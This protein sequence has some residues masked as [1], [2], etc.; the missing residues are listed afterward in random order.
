MKTARDD[1]IRRLNSIYANMLNKSN[2]SVI[3]GNAEFVDSK[4]LKVGN[5]FYSSDHICISVGG[6]P[7]MPK[8]PGVEHCLSSD[9]FFKLTKQPKKV[10]VYGGG[11]IGLEIAGVFHSLGTDTTLF[12]RGSPFQQFDELIRDTLL[13]ELSRQQLTISSGIE[14][15]EIKKVKDGELYLIDQQDRRHGPFE[16]ILMAI[17]RQPVTDSLSLSAANVQIDKNGFIPVNEY[18]ETSSRGIYAIGD[19]C[20]RMPTL[21]PM[22]IAAG[23]RLADRYA[24]I[25]SPPPSELSP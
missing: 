3:H 7:M 10:A 23:R 18:Q 9:E 8:V 4:V 20:G 17:G 21:T 13:Q 1:Y 24:L 12:T 16:E 11:Y 19:V 25:P 6:R 22:A 15:K 2:V 5:E 14:L